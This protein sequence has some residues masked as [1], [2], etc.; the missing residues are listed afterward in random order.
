MW[1]NRNGI[2]NILLIPPLE[3]YGYCITYDNTEDWLLHTPDGVQLKFNRDAGLS[4]FIPYIDI[5]DH[6]D[7]FV[8]FQI[9][10]KC[11]ERYIKNQVEKDILYRKAQV[12]IGDP[13][14]DKFKQMLSL[15]QIKNCPVILDDITNVKN[16]FYKRKINMGGNSEKKSIW[17]KMD[18]MLIAKYF[19]EIHKI[20]ILTEYVMFLKS[21]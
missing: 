1:L 6:S 4:N 7:V 8:M 14:E 3:Q 11:F 21:I 5:R 19:N 16:F 2:E 12:M 13:T 9:V 15:K 18:Y 20:V 10:R 17:V